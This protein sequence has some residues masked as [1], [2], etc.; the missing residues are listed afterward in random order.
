MQIEFTAAERTFR[1]AVREWL[2]KNVPKT[3]RPYHGEAMRLFDQDWQRRQYDAGW[4]GISWSKEFGGLGATLME[5][6]IW[7]EEYALAHAP[8]SGSSFVGLSHAGP[9]LIARGT[10]EQQMFHL[11]KILKGEAIWCQGFSEPGAGSDLAGLSTRAELDGDHFVVNGS[12]IWTSYALHAD[13]QELLVRTDLGSKKQGGISWVICDMKSP[14]IELRPILTMIAA[15]DFHFCQVFYN[16]VRIPIS[17]VVGEIN[18]GWSVANSTLGF[19]RGTGFIADQI[20]LAETVE[21]LLALARKRPGADGVTPVMEDGDIASRLAMLRAEM[22]AV[23]AMTYAT[24]S[25]AGRG[26]PGP[27]GSLVKLFFSEASQR[28]ARLGVDILGAEGLELS[29]D[30]G[31]TFSYLRSYAATIGGGTSDVQRNIIGERVLGLPKEG[32]PA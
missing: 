3:A 26:N 7:H 24:I 16:D 18:G 1:A 13:Y 25:R 23:R 6:L 5:Q 15:D 32:Y 20:R 4:A 11:P 28:V 30:E 12:K 19:E 27:E 14:G 22:A 17:N 10:R 9:T 31:T 21:M 2:N 29:A 8:R